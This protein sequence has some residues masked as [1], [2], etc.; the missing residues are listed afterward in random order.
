MNFNPIEQIPKEI[1]ELERLI[2]Q[3]LPHTRDKEK[4]E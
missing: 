1:E 2:K 4:I 3:G